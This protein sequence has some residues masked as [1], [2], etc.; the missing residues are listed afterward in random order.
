MGGGSKGSFYYFK[1]FLLI[2]FLIIPNISTQIFQHMNEFV[3]KVE[4]E[5][6]SNV[7]V[8]RVSHNVTR[9]LFSSCVSLQ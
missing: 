9:T 5:R 8:D 7:V 2:E 3:C 6:K 4:G 1:G